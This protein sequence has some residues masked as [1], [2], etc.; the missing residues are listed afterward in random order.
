MRT[1]MTCELLF[2]TRSTTFW[3]KSQADHPTFVST[4]SMWPKTTE[5]SCWGKFIKKLFISFASAVSCNLPEKANKETY[6]PRMLLFY[7]S[8]GNWFSLQRNVAGVARLR[9]AR[10]AIVA[11]IIADRVE[12]C[13]Y[14]NRKTL[15]SNPMRMPLWVLCIAMASPSSAWMLILYQWRKRWTFLITSIL[16]ADQ[17]DVFHVK[18]TQWNTSSFFRVPG[19]TLCQLQA[20]ARHQRVERIPAGRAFVTKTRN[21][22][23]QRQVENPIS[24]VAFQ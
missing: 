24:V 19:R 20:K 8:D 11:L 21:V 2:P 6:F 5:L 14:E 10:K 9:L 23:S 12:K 15:H 3:I 4:L 17:S 22:W 7:L 1:Q 18:W 13:M 16:S